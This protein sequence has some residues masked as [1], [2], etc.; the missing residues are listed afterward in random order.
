M[1]C[2]HESALRREQTPKQH[3]PGTHVENEFMM[4]SFKDFRVF[5][6]RCEDCRQI[7][8]NVR[9]LARGLGRKREICEWRG[10]L[11]IVEPPWDHVGI[12]RETPQNL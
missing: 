5:S 10:E 11:V 2:Y 4:I 9:R 6:L 8:I 3:R 1:V 7:V 12:L